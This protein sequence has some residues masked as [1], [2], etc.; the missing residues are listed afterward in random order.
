MR[1]GDF[2][3]LGENP[4]EVALLSFTPERTLLDIIGTEKMY[5]MLKRLT[6]GKQ[7]DAK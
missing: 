7:L 3:E 4:L 1:G 5:L 2:T 6:N